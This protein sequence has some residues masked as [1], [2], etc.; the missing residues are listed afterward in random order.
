MST[1]FNV[2]TS[3]PT[4]LGH[5]PFSTSTT[6]NTNNAY[7]TTAITGLNNLVN[8]LLPSV[9]IPGSTAG[10]TGNAGATFGIDNVLQIHNNILVENYGGASGTSFRTIIDNANIHLGWTGAL[11]PTAMQYGPTGYIGNI[12][13]LTIN[14]ITFPGSTPTI[15]M[16]LGAGSTATDKTQTF[17]SSAGAT[18]TLT[19]SNT[20][21]VIDNG[22][23]N[24]TMNNNSIVTNGQDLTITGGNILNLN[25][26]AVVASGDYITLTANNDYMTLSADDDITI[27][28]AGA[29][30]INLNAPNINSYN[31]AMPISFQYLFGGNW[32]YTLGSQVFEDV[33]GPS[34]P[35]IPLPTQFFADNPQSGYT[36]SRWELKFDMNCWNMGGT[37]ADKGFAIYLSFLDVNA[38]TYEPRIYKQLTPFCRWDNPAGFSIGP[39]SDFKSIN[40]ADTIDLGGLVNSFDS[41]LRLQMNIAGDSSMSCEFELKLGFTRTNRI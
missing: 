17:T 23:S 16:V 27:N 24:L 29:G 15:N 28:S 14:G 26:T 35:T 36:S 37:S 8:I 9:Q 25:G 32:S 3:T 5:A 19:V 30:N 40:F 21:V 31:W 10:R 12:N 7:T 11:G 6:N 20:S 4:N 2:A 18:Y 34:P 38:N 22:G 41:N 33:F 39:N 1:T 13:L